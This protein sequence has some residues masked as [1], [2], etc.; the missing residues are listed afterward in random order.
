[1]AAAARLHGSGDGDPRVLLLAV[2]TAARPGGATAE[3]GRGLTEPGGL[4]LLIGS[5]RGFHCF[6]YTV[7]QIGP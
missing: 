2:A 3:H 5:E 1:M 7:H 4:P 6:I